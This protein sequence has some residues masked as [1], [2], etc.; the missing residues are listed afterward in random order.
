M[1]SLGQTLRARP[2][3]SLAI[4]GFVVGAQVCCQHLPGLGWIILG[5]L[6]LGTARHML[7]SIGAPMG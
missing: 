2:Y 4:L 6:G 7:R 5:G 1:E 3:A